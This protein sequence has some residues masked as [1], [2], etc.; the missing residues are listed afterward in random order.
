MTPLPWRLPR[1]FRRRC[2]PPLPC[3]RGTG[4]GGWRAWPSGRRCRR[5]GAGCGG[6]GLGTCQPV[7]AVTIRPY[8]RGMVRG[9]G[10]MAGQL[11]P[12]LLLGSCAGGPSIGCARPAYRHPPLARH[13]PRA[14]RRC[15]T[16]GTLSLPYPLLRPALLL[17]PLPAAAARQAGPFR[18]GG[19][20]RE[21]LY[22]T[23][24]RGHAPPAGR[25]RPKRYGPAV[26]APELPRL[27]LAAVDRAPCPPR[28]PQPYGCPVWGDTPRCCAL[29]THP[30]FPTSCS[31]LNNVLLSP[32]CRPLR[33]PTTAAATPTA[34][35]DRAHVC[36]AAFP[37]CLPGQ[38]HPVPFT[39]VAHPPFPPRSP[40]LGA[41]LPAPPHL[42]V[43]LA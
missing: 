41:L 2:R 10:S 35:R 29:V 8:T 19:S 9:P 20:R 31:C 18:V 22:W 5:A 16:G 25:H 15:A 26:L 23:G 42:S 17:Y 37:L 1:R 4:D 14:G 11:P 30:P 39:F 12:R 24:G 43:C 6:G 34:H 32:S 21:G 3:G 27:L 28:G 38:P 40:T 33:T 13:R 7:S 36:T